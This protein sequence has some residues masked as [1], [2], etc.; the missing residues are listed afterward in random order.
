[1]SVIPERLDSNPTVPGISALF[2][3]KSNAHIFRIQANMT[4]K[5]RLIK[6]ADRNGPDSPI[7]AEAAADPREWSTAVKSWVK[8]FQDDRPDGSPEP[9]NN[10]FDE[11]TP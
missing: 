1:M 10:L 8:E 2:Q 5:V 7:A 6:R 11:P 3:F 4:A 9:F